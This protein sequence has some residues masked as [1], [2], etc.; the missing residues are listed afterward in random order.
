MTSEPVCR[1]VSES[2]QLW[3]LTNNRN[4]TLI[5]FVTLNSIQ[6]RIVGRI[7]KYCCSLPYSKRARVGSGQFFC[8][9]GWI[10]GRAMS[11]RK[12][13]KPVRWRETMSFP[14]PRIIQDKD[15]KGWYN[16][17]FVQIYELW[18]IINK[19]LRITS[20]LLIWTHQPP[21][22]PG[23]GFHRYVTPASEPESLTDKTLPI[24]HGILNLRLRY[25]SA[26][27]EW[28]IGKKALIGKL[29]IP[30]FPNQGK[31]YYVTLNFTK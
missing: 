2:C 27:S 7:I 22:H 19:N 8:H 17:Q 16:I 24:L 3:V 13:T 12:R 14:I 18:K 29:P 9:S 30:T 28:R 11:E 31:E 15:R 23:R 21:P 4:D 25:R 10:F 5:L 26:C 1:A 20:W 6:S